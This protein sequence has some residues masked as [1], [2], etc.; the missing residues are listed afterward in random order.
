MIQ[1][2]NKLCFNFRGSSSIAEEEREMRLIGGNV[3]HL[4][5][6]LRIWTN[7]KTCRHHT[8]DLIS[9]TCELFNDQDDS[10]IE[11]LL[12]LLD[13]HTSLN[14]N[15]N[16][17]PSTYI[18]DSLS[19]IS[20][21]TASITPALVTE[22]DSETYALPSQDMGHLLDIF[23]PVDGFDC[24]IRTISNDHSVILDFL[25]SNETCFLLYF[26]RILKYFNKNPISLC[27]HPSSN[28]RKE[29][30]RKTWSSIKK[31]T[32]KSLFPYDISPVLKLLDKVVVLFDGPE[33]SEIESDIVLS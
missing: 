8:S 6:R 2:F 30:L 16:M 27:S 24:L 7:E 12:C 18:Q 29:V 13:I 5:N 31:L 20:N 1:S 11:S 21:L 3:L 33:K 32:N 14:T 4:L 23:N 28:S 25:L 17:R 19:S 9:T 26:L 22:Y 15:Y 10:L